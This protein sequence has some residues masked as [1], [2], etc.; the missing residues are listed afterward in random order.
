MRWHQTLTKQI[1]QECKVG[2]CYLRSCVNNV[3]DNCSLDSITIVRQ[4][5]EASCQ[6]Y[7]T[8]KESDLR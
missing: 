5:N 1:G 3:N 2:N 4:G 8:V 7:D 6:Q